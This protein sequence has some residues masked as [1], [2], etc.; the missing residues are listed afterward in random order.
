M[1][2]L[3]SPWLYF[4]QSVT[5]YSSSYSRLCYHG[6]FQSTGGSKELPAEATYAAHLHTC[7][8]MPHRSGFTQFH[9][10]CGHLVL[11][12]VYKFSEESRAATGHVQRSRLFSVEGNHFNC[13]STLRCSVD[14]MF[15]WSYNLTSGSFKHMVQE[16][17]DSGQ[18]DCP[19]GPK[20]HGRESC[21][22]HRL[23]PMSDSL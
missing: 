12:L 11:L 6:H 2:S 20:G 7:V 15:P 18:N 3:H 9:V 5:V 8:Q 4:A 23:I 21:V 19:Y 14:T 13:D 16:Y 17:R 10:P 1:L 22:H